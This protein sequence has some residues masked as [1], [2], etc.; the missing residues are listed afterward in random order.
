VAV[1]SNNEK[2]LVD[3]EGHVCSLASKIDSLLLIESVHICPLVLD[4]ICAHLLACL[5]R[6]HLDGG[7]LQT[8]GGHACLSARR[9]LFYVGAM[10]E[11]M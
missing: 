6:L 1:S 8:S 5:Q 4:R 2:A 11:H 3:N 7:V 9:D 10:V